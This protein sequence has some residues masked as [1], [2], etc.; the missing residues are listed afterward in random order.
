MT[1]E[2]VSHHTRQVLMSLPTDN[3][4][5]Y[6]ISRM[7]DELR[8]KHEFELRI[9]D[10]GNNNEIY[11]KPVNSLALSVAGT[12]EGSSEN[13]QASIQSQQTSA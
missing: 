2:S 3:R 1:R 4:A 11:I 12:R 6:S 10:I 5:E 9:G 8:A 7:I 13:P